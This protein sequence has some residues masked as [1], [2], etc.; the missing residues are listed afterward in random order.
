MSR[1]IK[2]DVVSS[3][4]IFGSAARQSMDSMSDR[5]ILIVDDDFFAL[6]RRK[7]CLEEQGWS[8]ASYSFRRLQN[9]SRNGGLFVQHLKQESIIIVDHNNRL[10]EILGS[11]TPKSSYIDE[12]SKNSNLSNLIS[13]YPDTK[14]GALW[15][16][17]MLYVTL[18]NFGILTL[19]GVGCYKFSF[20]EIVDSLQERGLIKC[21]AVKSSFL[22]LRFLKSLYRENS[23]CNSAPV[24]SC[25]NQCI[26]GLSASKAFPVRIKPVS[27]A[28][29]IDVYRREYNENMGSYYCLRHLEKSIVSFY[30]LFPR[31]AENDLKI[32]NTWIKN[33][34]NYAWASI[35]ESLH[36][37][38]YMKFIMSKSNYILKYRY[39]T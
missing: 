12:I 9:L 32:I 1:C 11:F 4:A 26:E 5:D 17:D 27:P 30:D 13:Y 14:R 2:G 36:V 24:I 23:V 28:Y 33:P 10:K 19:A 15:A 31:I 22:K 20:E 34:R 3:E 29:V 25:I 35:N 6:C 7:A 8:V 38:N 16:A 39:K 21:G 37:H 18:R